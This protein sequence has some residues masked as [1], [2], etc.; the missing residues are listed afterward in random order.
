MSP[1]GKPPISLARPA[2]RVGRWLESVLRGAGARPEAREEEP[3]HGVLIPLVRP[4]DAAEWRGLD[5]FL[6]GLLDLLRGLFDFHSAHVFL[7][8]DDG[9]SLVQRA[10]TARGELP[11]RLA[12]I[13]VGSGLVGWVAERGR[14]ITV[15][16]LRRG[17]RPTGYVRPDPIVSFAAAPIVAG[18][19]TLGVL[20]VDHVVSDAFPSPRTEAALAAVAAQVGRIL[21]AE[22]ALAEARLAAAAAAAAAEIARP[23]AA[24]ETLDA[25]AESLV[26]G[27]ARSAETTAVGCFLVGA[28]GALSLRAHVGWAD[29]WGSN[30]RRRSAE[31]FAEQ[32]I[33]LARPVR[34]G[35][36]ASRTPTGI[37]AP[38]P[39]PGR[40]VGAVVVEASDESLRTIEPILLGAA[41]EVG[42]TLVRIFRRIEAERE[43]ERSNRLTAET[44]RL[45]AAETADA[46]WTAAAAILAER[47]GM[48]RPPPPAPPAE[49]GA[50]S[51]PVVLAAAPTAVRLAAYRRAGDT[52]W[53]LEAAVG[54]VRAAAT[55]RAGEGLVGWAAATGRAVA[56]ADVAAETRGIPVDDAGALLLVP[57]GGGG[58]KPVEA[59]AVVAGARGS[60]GP[61]E[62][63]S[64]EDLRPTL[65]VLHRRLPAPATETRKRSAA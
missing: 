36:P 46:F 21:S 1:H 55:L 52:G 23:A 10:Y 62:A 56:V 20:A 25:A 5:D 30:V 64:V 53:R 22:G 40:M 16:D 38:I 41:P 51:A 45:A 32:A 34:F 4:E 15:G 18:G 33:S 2:S 59:I 47:L 19:K 31:K 65:A 57:I 26:T 44:L 24:A 7:A 49:E 42:A 17:G 35:A 61:R 14:A 37:A 11:C 8:S 12:T 28:G 29:L 60:L 6:T 50:A 48:H 39:G 63:E 54:G 9:R 27:L 3:T 43:A 13:R 58:G